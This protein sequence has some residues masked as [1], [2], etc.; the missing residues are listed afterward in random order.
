[1]KAPLTEPAQEELRGKE[2]THAFAGATA[3]L[4]SMACSLLWA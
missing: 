3:G 4:I 1:M 2:E